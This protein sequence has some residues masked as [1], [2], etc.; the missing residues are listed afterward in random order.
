MLPLRYAPWWRVANVTLLGGVFLGT[1]LPA[2]WFRGRLDLALFDGIDKLMHFLVF[3]VLAL[4]FSGQYSLHNWWRIAI[5]L[6]LFGAI[7][8]IC[9]QFTVSRSAEWLDFA[10]D[11]AG[12]AVGL[13]IA[14]SGL[15]GWSLRVEN[16]LLESR[17]VR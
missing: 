6:A 2:I 7:I 9:Q 3:T 10:A 12:I 11:V 1:L 14:R 17:G 16:W 15:S 5:G 13:L 8:E 4:W